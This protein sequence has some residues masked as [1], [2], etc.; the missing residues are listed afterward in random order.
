[1]K[2]SLRDPGNSLGQRCGWEG[3]GPGAITDRVAGR[4]EG[5]V[6]QLLQDLG[7]LTQAHPSTL[8]KEASKTWYPLMSYFCTWAVSGG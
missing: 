8:D 6:A 5:E 4:V 3:T 1:M 2:A 7:D